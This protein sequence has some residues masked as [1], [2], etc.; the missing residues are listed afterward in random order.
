MVASELEPRERLVWSADVPDLQALLDRIGAKPDLQ[1]IKI[2]RL[3]VE[4]HGLDVIGSLQ[5]LGIQVFYDAKLVEIPSKIEALTKKIVERRPAMLNCMGTCV[6]NG[7]MEVTPDQ[8]ELDGLKRFA[9]VCREA[10]VMPIGV[11]V[12]TSKTL[13][14]AQQEF[15]AAAPTQ[16]LRYVRWLNEAGFGGVVCSPQ[17]VAVIRGESQHDHLELWTPGVRLPGGDTQDQARTDTPGG[18]IAAGAT[19][20][21][22]GRELTNDDDGSNCDRM[23]AEIAAA[24]A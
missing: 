21:I 8:S 13:R 14:V 10:D 18:A 15:R 2:D 11:T 20:V 24:A 19:R 12:L 22:S 6:S 23:I 7:V 3:F 5:Q 17:E 16:V 9:D 4:T 1:V